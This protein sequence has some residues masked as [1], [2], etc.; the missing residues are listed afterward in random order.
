VG[1]REALLDDSRLLA[2]RM[3][4]S[5]SFVELVVYSGM[6]HVWQTFVGRFREA[7]DSIAA[8]GTFLQQHLQLPGR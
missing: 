8:L 6:W 1:E 3:T 7:D 4:A 2:Q 5:G